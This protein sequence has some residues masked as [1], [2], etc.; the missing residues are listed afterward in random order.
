M[1]VLSD[2]PT[3]PF[4]VLKVLLEFATKKNHFIFDGEYND[5][6]NWYRNKKISLAPVSANIFMC[7][8]EEKRVLNIDP[9]PSNWFRYAD[10]SFTLFY[11]R[12]TAFNFLDYP[13]SWTVTVVIITN[14]IPFFDI[15]NKL[16][17]NVF[18]TSIYR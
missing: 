15:I 5:Q 4:S 11:S 17:N 7:H 14:V 12:T 3:M 9:R 6:N 13:N 10:Y 2:L 1:Y 8:F 18:S 16:Q